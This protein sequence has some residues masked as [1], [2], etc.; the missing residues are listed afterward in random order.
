MA[1]V[2]IANIIDPK[3]HN[4]FLELCAS[5]T[6][7]V[8]MEPEDAA[9]VTEQDTFGVVTK[10]SNVNEPYIDI[11]FDLITPHRLIEG[12]KYEIQMHGALFYIVQIEVKET[13][14]PGT[15]KKEPVDD[16]DT[17]VQD[18]IFDQ[19]EPE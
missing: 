7:M 10:A 9:G 14:V 3:T 1:S 17:Y 5:K 19:P 2:K 8:V 16:E 15:L 4:E 11:E 12:S 13:Y 18:T 6:L